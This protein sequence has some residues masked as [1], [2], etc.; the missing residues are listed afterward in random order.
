MCCVKKNSPEPNGTRRKAQGKW[1]NDVFLLFIPCAFGLEPYP[2]LSDANN[3]EDHKNN[4]TRIK[5][6]WTRSP[7]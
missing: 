6:S 7:S 5:Q 1:I 2:L 3:L 4:S